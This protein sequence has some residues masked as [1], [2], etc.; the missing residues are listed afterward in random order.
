MGNSCSPGCLLVMS[1]MASICAVHFP[2]RCLGW[3]LGL[4]F[5]QFLRVFLPTFTAVNRINKTKAASFV[6]LICF[7][8]PKGLY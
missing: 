5:S 8:L 4:N 2:T 1:F 3:D 6:S 7:L